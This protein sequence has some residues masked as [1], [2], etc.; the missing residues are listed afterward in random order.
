MLRSMSHCAGCGRDTAP[1]AASYDVHIEV[2]AAAPV[3]E[4]DDARLASDLSAE[5]EHLGC[6]L[7]ALRAE[8]AEKDVHQEFRFVLCRRC[9]D[10][11]VRA[12]LPDLGLGAGSAAT[13][14]EEAEMSR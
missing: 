12:P 2:M 14:G 6:E 7:E 1:E 13:E 3:L 4:I 10:A 8:E 9:R 11:Y 5:L